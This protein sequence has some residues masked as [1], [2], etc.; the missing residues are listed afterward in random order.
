MKKTSRFYEK[1][2]NEKQLQVPRLTSKKINAKEKA[3][4]V[5]CLIAS[6]LKL[7]ENI[8]RCWF[9]LLTFIRNSCYQIDILYDCILHVTKKG[10]FT[11][12]ISAKILSQIASEISA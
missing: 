5:Y 1:K 11:I 12:F 4:L 10:A 2:F 9:N 7:K 8:Q 3:R 6:I